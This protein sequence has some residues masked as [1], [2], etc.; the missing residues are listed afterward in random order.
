MTG[1]HTRAVAAFLTAPR[2]L[3][4]AAAMAAPA[5]P[6]PSYA[7]IDGRI[8]DGVARCRAD[9]AKPA[10]VSTPDGLVWSEQAEVDAAELRGEA[11]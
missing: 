1:S 6:S 8:R 3:S 7:R 4:L 5:L 2:N 11:A 9:A 10:P